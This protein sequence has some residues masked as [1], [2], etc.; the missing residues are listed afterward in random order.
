MEK[1]KY[2][3]VI[4]RYYRL[5]AKHTITRDT[6]WWST[7]AVILCAMK[8]D[9]ITADDYCYLL[10]YRDELLES[11]EKGINTPDESLKITTKPPNGVGCNRE[12]SKII[13]AEK[14]NKCLTQSTQSHSIPNGRE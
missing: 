6:A 12:H 1:N 8:D 10:D 3:E 5:S 7:Q 11:L 9:R 14:A 4:D 13:T 2:I